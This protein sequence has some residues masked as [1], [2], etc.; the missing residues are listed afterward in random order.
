MSAVDHFREMLQ[1]RKS[2]PL[3]RLR[4]E[5]DVIAHL[6][7]INTGLQQTPGLIGM[8]LDDTRGGDI[9]PNYEKI[10]VVFNATQNETA[11]TDNTLT[12]LAL[13]L[14]PVQK[15]KPIRCSK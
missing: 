2:S 10:V 15:T 13:E 7:F 11:F 14:H 8:V 6:S 4:T 1:I 5:A 9:D 3:F 12:G